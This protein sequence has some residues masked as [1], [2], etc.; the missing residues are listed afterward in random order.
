MD[1]ENWNNNHML[2]LDE[3]DPDNYPTLFK[4]WQAMRKNPYQPNLLNWK[5]KNKDKLDKE[6][7]TWSKSFYSKGNKS[8]REN[9]WN[10]LGK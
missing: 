4:Y 10:L 9:L 3:I 6:I 2:S 7:N 5:L 1:K 8:H